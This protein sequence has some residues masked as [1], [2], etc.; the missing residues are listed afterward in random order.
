MSWY[1]TRAPERHLAIA[2]SALMGMVTTLSSTHER[3]AKAAYGMAVVR[4]TAEVHNWATEIILA[5]LGE[6]AGR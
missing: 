1:Q 6:G 3:E 4:Q 5:C 2:A